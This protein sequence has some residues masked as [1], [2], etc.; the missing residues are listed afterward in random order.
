MKSNYKQM[1]IRNIIIVCGMLLC[2]TVGSRVTFA[3]NC[4]NKPFCSLNSDTINDKLSDPV[5]IEDWEPY[6]K[7]TN[8]QISSFYRVVLNR[9]YCNN[10]IDSISDS[11]FA[12]RLSIYS[13]TITNI[14]IGEY[15]HYFIS[16][17]QG[18]PK[19]SKR[20]GFADLSGG[21]LYE[22]WDCYTLPF[23]T[24][25]P[26]S[27]KWIRNNMLPSYSTVLK[28]LSY[29]DIY[30]R[31][32]RDIVRLS[33]CCLQSLI[34]N[35]IDNLA[36]EYITSVYCSNIADI[37]YIKSNYPLPEEYRR[38]N[39]S[40]TRNYHII[41]GFWLKRYIDGSFI[42]FTRMLET[43]LINY[44]RD[45]FIEQNGTSIFN[46]AEHIVH[47]ASYIKRQ[48]CIN[49]WLPD[50]SP[51]VIHKG[52]IVG[53]KGK[54]EKG[55]LN[56]PVR[57]NGIKIIG[58]GENDKNSSGVFQRKNICSLTLSDSIE[59]IAPYTFADN[60]LRHVELP[61]KLSVV[62]T[63]VFYNNKLDSIGFA[64][65]S[66]IKEIKPG[67]FSNNRIRSLQM[68]DSLKIISYVSF[69]HNILDSIYIPAGVEQI[70]YGAFINNNIRK[71][72]FA[73]NCNL[74]VINHSAF[75]NNNITYVEIPASVRIISNGAFNNNPLDSITFFTDKLE[76]FY[77]PD[78]KRVTQHGLW[79]TPSGI[80]RSVA[81]KCTEK[82][83]Y[84]YRIENR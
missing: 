48:P 33:Y 18:V 29:N 65:Q 15:I 44:D 22:L 32:F 49:D 76:C 17:K 11:E 34:E 27:V 58:I 5:F 51:W 79:L 78:N 9:L 1:I 63:G 36:V 38:Y 53:Y 4:C 82:G 19:E 10:N 46:K 16:A 43:I 3:A 6:K 45:W 60:K 67:A 25:L 30:N 81:E 71:L 61:T 59:F 35:N 69:A 70:K 73:D 8:K 26:E 83:L 54:P 57:I 21:Y 24:Y 7:Y 41:I 64:K 80:K 39:K 31:T 68:P 50:M 13:D 14:D 47:S 23:D 40:A 28:G 12:D 56:I 75:Q 84:I 77:L 72:I 42:E 55:I 2:I 66:A 52:V 62:E 37:D 20:W 74:E